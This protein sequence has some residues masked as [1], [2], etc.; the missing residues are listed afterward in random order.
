MG[1][2]DSFEDRLDRLVNGAFARAFKSEVQPVEIAAALTRELEDRAAIVARSRTVVPNVFTAELS[3]HDFS[4][5]STYR[6]TLEVEF[7]TVVREYA[8]DQHYTLLGPV[9]VELVEDDELETGIFRLRS[10]ARSAVSAPGASAAGAASTGGIAGARLI[11][12]D[13]AYP[14]L[15][16]VTTLGRGAEADI[17]VDDPG[18]SRHHCDIILGSPTIVRDA[19]STNG[20]YVD[21]QKVSQLALVD[22]S[23]LRIG[24]TTL[25]FRST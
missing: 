22:G 3:P 19:K 6:E 9:T 2:L 10:E 7:A 25:I 18:V 24:T 15:A 1:L 4:R 17:R 5:L 21:G 8:D 16:A 12:G 14:L 20:T 13:T 11:A 23:A